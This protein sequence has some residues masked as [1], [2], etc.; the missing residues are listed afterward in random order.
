M[1][2]PPNI[3]ILMLDQM[4][5]DFT[6]MES[7]PYVQMPNLA[8]LAQHGVYFSDAV[9]ASPICV[10][11]RQA[12]LSGQ[13]PQHCGC[14]NWGQDIAP[15]V[16]TYP[17]W[18]AAHGYHTAAAGKMHLQGPDQMKGWNRRIGYDQV[19]PSRP[20]VAVKPEDRA[21]G[22]PY[23]PGTGK[24]VWDDEMRKAG[25]GEGYWNR[26]DRYAVDGA[27]M[28]LDQ[29]F[30]GP[31]YDRIGYQPLLLQ[32]S[33]L[34]PHFPYICREEWFR[35]YLNRVQPVVEN[36]ADEHPCHTGRRVV[37]GEDVTERELQRTWA[38]YCGM[39][40]E[41]DELF[42][43]VIQRLKDLNVF[44]DFVVVFQ[45]DHG[46]MLGNH[47]IW[48]KYVFFEEALRAPLMVSYPAASWA[49]KT[50]RGPVSH[51]D[52]YPTLC[53][54]AGIPHPDELDG[55]SLAPCLTDHQTE[56]E[57][58]V[59][60]SELD[61][62]SLLDEKKRHRWG[63]GRQLMIRDG[64]LKFATYQIPGWPDQ[65]FDLAADPKERNNLA[66]DAAQADV[67]RRFRK[68]ANAFWEQARRPAF[69]VKEGDWFFQKTVE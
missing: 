57:P 14:R 8:A 68:L 48:E 5:S 63:Q 61:C 23:I 11:G 36:P 6:P 20:A 29:Y 47:G 52:L 42:G 12:I 13:Y 43:K 31:D 3:L 45:S 17:A 10:P 7:H 19:A 39:I 66:G 41:A 25:Y 55:V 18:F 24:W 33:L 49:P 60:Y 51:L 34:M 54:L 58:R 44:D 65:L 9:T 35:Y 56:A 30:G 62:Y 67:V 46:D 59:I 28:F 40:S 4:R 1:Q 26:H 22:R 53:D 2:Q 38:A 21:A 50:V 27:L 15:D 32:V 69:P 64:D 37:I 16:I